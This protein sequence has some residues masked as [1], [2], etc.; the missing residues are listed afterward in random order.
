MMSRGR[1]AVLEYHSTEH[2]G[3]PQHT[4]KHIHLRFDHRIKPL[5]FPAWSVRSRL[6]PRLVSAR[7][8]YTAPLS[9]RNLPK[10]IPSSLSLTCPSLHISLDQPHRDADLTV[11]PTRF[12]SRY[13]N[14][15]LISIPKTF[16]P[17]PR[18]DLLFKKEKIIY[19][20]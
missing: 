19:Q 13:T 20:K 15:P 5:W 14:M 4:N 9:G 10:R 11:S 8:Q 3:V 1:P 18:H 17:K 16:Q 2:S 6:S 7:Q 12:E